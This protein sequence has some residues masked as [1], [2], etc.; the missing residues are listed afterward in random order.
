MIDH[1]T[2]RVPD[3]AEGRRFYGLALELLAFPGEP[4]SGGG[5]VEWNDF[6]ITEQ[7]A[8]RPATR[9]LH[10]GFSAASTAMVD[11]WWAAMTGAGHRSDGEP[12]PRPEY[13]PEYYGAFVLDA[14]GNSVEAVHNGPRRQPGVIDHLWLRTV[15]LEA[16]SRFYETVCPLVGHTV[17]RYEGRTQVRGSGATFSVVAGPPTESVHLAFQASDRAAVDAFHAAG[18]AAGYRSFGEPGERPAYQPGYYAAF[19][20][21]PDGH[22]VEAVCRDR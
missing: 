21:D 4:A 7:S 14:A 1:V 13:G 3:L 20:L 8:D 12:G 17:H 22:A 11:G 6:S 10:I 16:A 5:F 18:V 2:I 15:S 9:R 19:L